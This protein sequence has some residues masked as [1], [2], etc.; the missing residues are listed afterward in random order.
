MTH[1]L[2]IRCCKLFLS[3]PIWW[4]FFHVLKH[5]LLISK[6]PIWFGLYSKEKFLFIIFGITL[7]ILLFYLLRLWIIPQFIIN[8]LNY[9]S[10]KKYTLFFIT[11]FISF[12]PSIQEGAKVGED[13]SGQ[14][15][16]ILQ[17]VNGE[18]PFPNLVNKP[19]T[20]DLALDVNIWSIRP[21][22]GSFIPLPG[23]FIGVPIGLSL[24]ISIFSCLLFGGLF[25]IIFFSNFFD[26]KLLTF[27]SLM[28]GLFAGT[29]SSLYSTSNIILYLFFPLFLN[30]LLY[31]ED[32]LG[33]HG[34][35]IKFYANIFA[36][37]LLT[38]FFSWIKLSG[39]ICAGTLSISLFFVCI[40]TINTK[41]RFRFILSFLVI[42]FI[43][44]IPFLS[45]EYLN[46]HFT[47]GTAEELYSANDSDVQSPLFGKYWGESTRSIWLLWSVLAAP[48]YAL[49]VKTIAYSLQE[50]SQQ[51]PT[52]INFIHQFKINE[53]VL[54]AG[55]L[56]I[57][58]TM[59][60]FKLTNL[61]SISFVGRTL[62]ISFLIIPFVGLGILAYKFQWNYLIYHSHTYEYWYIFLFPLLYFL[63]N[64][65]T[66]LCSFLLFGI[67]IAYPTTNLLS[68]SISQ[69]NLLHKDSFISNTEQK[70]ALS[71]SRF[72]RAIETIESDSECRRDLLLFLPK[73]DMSDLIVR[74]KMRTLAVHFAGDNLSKRDNFFTSE[75][76]IVY[77]AYDSSL[78]EEISFRHNLNKKFPQ[79][80]KR[81]ILFSESITVEKLLLS[82]ESIPLT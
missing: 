71:N 66:T 9:L 33:R 46:H 17:W 40:H 52:F 36:F 74:T 24:Q 20:N 77:C 18:V 72:S 43:F 35:T 78:L 8:S 11:A 37:L 2:S 42:S 50:L 53:Q 25:W 29:S 27:L 57:P 73:G 69:I 15:K 1:S 10:K 65:K 26:N 5:S 80:V 31:I 62:I 22:I 49:P 68:K 12:I 4:L 21:P 47:G 30:W 16:G 45:L 59:Y 64:Q 70:R 3:L 63:Q 51:F 39:I 48:G 82:P 81:E 54:V 41:K 60:L 28:F 6:N 19:S 76:I 14:I 7:S 75:E 44:W 38:G 55:L 61:S 34:L 67:S 32:F 58:I 56:C 13:M 23:M 79:I